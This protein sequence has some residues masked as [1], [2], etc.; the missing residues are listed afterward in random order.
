MKDALLLP[1]LLDDEKD[2]ST[3]CTEGGLLFGVPRVGGRGGSETVL[4]EL[5]GAT[6]LCGEFLIEPGRREGGGGGLLPLSLLG[7]LGSTV[8]M[9]LLGTSSSTLRDTLPEL[10][11]LSF[12]S[13]TIWLCLL[14][15]GGAGAIF[16][17]MDEDGD[18][19]SGVFPRD[20][21]SNTDSRSES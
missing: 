7:L 8:A 1:V 20:S 6:L 3:L 19:G 9:A 18:G 2:M 13:D 12:D 11:R 21:L 16:L 4:G 5:N 17:L 10:L 15:S 14:E